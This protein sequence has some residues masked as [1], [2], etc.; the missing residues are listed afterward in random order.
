MWVLQPSS[1]TITSINLSKGGNAP[2]ST[3]VGKHKEV[4]KTMQYTH[5]QTVAFGGIQEEARREVR[6]SG[7]LRTQPN[8]D[9]TQMERAMMVAKKR[10]ETQVI[11]YPASCSFNSTMGFT[12]PNGAAGGYGYWMQ[13]DASGCSGLLF[14]DYWVATS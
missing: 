5:E 11:G 2:V 7:R 10:A 9:M 12:S 14:P 6:S 3:P 4:P 13:S 8:T 1:M